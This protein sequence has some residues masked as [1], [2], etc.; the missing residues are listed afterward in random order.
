MSWSWIVAV[1]LQTISHGS[2]IIYAVFKANCIIVNV[3][4]LPDSTIKNNHFHTWSSI[5]VFLLP[6]KSIHSVYFSPVNWY[7]LNKK[8]FFTTRSTSLDSKFY[9]DIGNEDYS[10]VST[11]YYIS[12]CCWLHWPREQTLTTKVHLCFCLMT[13]PPCFKV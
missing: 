10:P 13:S 11:I 8:K 3:K 12:F 1:D 5:F 9:C 4:I 6:K 2:K 7:L